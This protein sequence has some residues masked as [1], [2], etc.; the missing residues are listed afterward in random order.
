MKYKEFNYDISEQGIVK[1]INTGRIMKPEIQ[2]SGY[3]RVTLCASGKTH[4]YLLHRLVALC[5][6]P[7]KEG[8]PCVNH[9]DGDKSNNCVEN[10]EWVTYSE[11]EL[12]SIHVLGKTGSGRKPTIPQETINEMFEM[13]KMGST[14][15]LIAERVGCSRQYVSEILSGKKRNK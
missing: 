10:L 6:I 7:N 2:K 5:Y 14:Q 3:H 15:K 9:K 11:N 8:K 13:R 1:N 12:H 4:R